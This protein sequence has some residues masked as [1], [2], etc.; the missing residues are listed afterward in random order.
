MIPLMG[1]TMPFNLIYYLSLITI[2]ITI[3]LYLIPDLKHFFLWAPLCA[4]PYAMP[5]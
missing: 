4:G 5:W 2:F 3:Q 1:I